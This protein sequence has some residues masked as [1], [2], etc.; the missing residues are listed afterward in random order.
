MA[1]GKRSAF[2]LIELLTSMLI[3]VMVATGIGLA[4]RTSLA[5]RTSLDDGLSTMMHA[6]ETIDF[7]ESLVHRAVRDNSFPFGLMETGATPDS[8]GIHFY[9]DL[10]DDGTAEW[11]W[12][13]RDSQ[14]LNMDSWPYTPR[15]PIKVTAFIRKP[16]GG[17]EWNRTDSAA[18][19]YNMVNSD[20]R[21]YTVIASHASQFQFYADPP[22]TN[23]NPTRLRIDAGFHIH[24]YPSSTAVFA[25]DWNQVSPG[26]SSNQTV[27]TYTLTRWTTPRS[28]DS[29]MSPQGNAWSTGP[30][31]P[32][33]EPN[34]AQQRDWSINYRSAIFNTPKSTWM[35]R[36]R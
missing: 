25:L 8:R 3:G 29:T 11:V 24:N 2:T 35:L 34:P 26:S 10:D 18:V 17:N 28:L 16:P 27:P 15:Y 13:W 19:C 6:H 36:P 12:I 9:A 21:C 4:L 5:A 14:P 30:S 23:P 20:P 7:I 33:Q 31:A 22:G 1:G 32:P